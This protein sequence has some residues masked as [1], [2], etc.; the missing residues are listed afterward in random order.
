MSV[1]KAPLR[2]PLSMISVLVKDPREIKKKKQKKRTQR[3]R[4]R[5]QMSLQLR[6]PKKSCK[7]AVTHLHC[8]DKLPVQSPEHLLKS[9]VDAGLVS[10]LMLC[11]NGRLVLLYHIQLKPETVYF[12]VV[13]G[14]ILPAICVGILQEW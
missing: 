10:H 4:L 3:F 14:H 8:W 6:A 13:L 11:W 1:L 7:D 2:C 9:M 12:Y 5:R